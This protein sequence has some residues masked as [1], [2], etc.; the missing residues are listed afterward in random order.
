MSKLPILVLYK[1]CLGSGAVLFHA[2]FFLSS[3]ARLHCFASA[4]N[5]LGKLLVGHRW[6]SGEGMWGRPGALGN[7]IG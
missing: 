4:L 7:V 3:S 5:L 2:V 1:S 6:G